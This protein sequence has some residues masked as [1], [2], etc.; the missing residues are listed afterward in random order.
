MVG[1][2][3]VE[4]VRLIERRRFPE[5]HDDAC[6]WD[7]LKARIARTS[8]DLT[9]LRTEDS[10]VYER[11]SRAR[12]AHSGRQELA[13]ALVQAVGKVAYAEGCFGKLLLREDP[14]TPLLQFKSGGRPP[15]RPDGPGLGI[16]L[17][18]S[19][20]DRWTLN[21]VSIPN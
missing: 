20:L 21:R 5:D 10:Q 13:L 2:A 11:L 1:L 8:A 3:L 12:N 14:A 4:K 15:S 18:P 16:T 6:F 19:I 17:D 7:A 9:E